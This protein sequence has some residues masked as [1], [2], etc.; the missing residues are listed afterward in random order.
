MKKRCYGTWLKSSQ[1]KMPRS[2]QHRLE[3]EQELEQENIADGQ[4]LTYDLPSILLHFSRIVNWLSV[5][6]VVSI[7]LLMLLVALR[8][9]KTM[10]ILNQ[11]RIL[12]RA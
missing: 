4:V 6:H 10:R 1:P 8:M 9:W 7:L 11:L 3:Q 5:K 2:T 12:Q